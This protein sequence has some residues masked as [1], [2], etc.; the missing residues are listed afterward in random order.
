MSLSLS[1]TLLSHEFIILH[2][3][4]DIH[5]DWQIIRCTLWTHNN[6]KCIFHCRPYHINKI[7]RFCL[8]ETS[9]VAHTLYLIMWRRKLH[10]IVGRCNFLPNWVHRCLGAYLVLTYNFT[11]NYCKLQCR[12]STLFRKLIKKKED[13]YLLG[14]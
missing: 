1:H 11:C 6:F 14:I 2:I 13:R 4:S 5:W 8:T 12:S 10:L 3:Y 7:S 9:H